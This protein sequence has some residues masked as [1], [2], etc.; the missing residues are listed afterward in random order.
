MATVYLN[1][2]KHSIISAYAP[3]LPIS[4]KN[5]NIRDSFYKELDSVIQGISKRNVLIIGG[6]FNAKAGSGYED[7]KENMGRFGRGKINSNGEHL[8]DLASRHDLVLTNTLFEHKHAHRTTWESPDKA[9]GKKIRNQIDYILVRNYHR[10]FV[11][12]SRSYA[13]TQTF[14]DHRLVMA[15]FNIN[16]QRKTPGKVLSHKF[17]I[18]KLKRP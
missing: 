17:D 3:T 11:E 5:P 14:S 8:L 9:D 16:W 4:E 10:I 13:G 6:D 2:R 18:E 7:H 12:D 1:N 15:K